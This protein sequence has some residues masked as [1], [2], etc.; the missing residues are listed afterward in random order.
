[1]NRKITLNLVIIIFLT[2]LPFG[3]AGEEN[4]KKTLLDDFKVVKIS[5]QEKMAVI[6]STD[7]NLQII[8]VGDKIG[9]NG[10]V[11]EIT[12]GRI[13]IEE[14]TDRGMETVIIRVENGDQSVERISRVVMDRG[15]LYAPST[16]GTK[17]HEG[18]K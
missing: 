9:T 6:K 13:V 17:E 15:Q 2:S 3:I 18:K 14:L 11:T 10:K 16:K 1:M 7:E 8:K 12:K 5:V 4:L